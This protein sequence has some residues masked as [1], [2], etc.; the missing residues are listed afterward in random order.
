MQATARMAPPDVSEQSLQH[1]LLSG[2]LS[3]LA[4]WHCLLGDGLITQTGVRGPRGLRHHLNIFKGSSRSCSAFIGPRLLHLR[5]LL[6]QVPTSGHDGCQ[7]D[8]ISGLRFSMATI[9]AEN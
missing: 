7:V 6:P 8:E 2:R 1:C 9:E 5:Q 3:A 4:L